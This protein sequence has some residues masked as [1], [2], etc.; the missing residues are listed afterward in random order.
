[1]KYKLLL[2]GTNQ[3]LISD[4]FIHMEANFECMYSS[5]RNADIMCHLKYYHPDAVVFCLHRD[6]KDDISRFGGVLPKLSSER[7]S[8]IIVGEDENCE[9]FERT[10]PMAVDLAIRKPITTRGLEEELLSFL[11]RIVAEKEEQEKNAEWKR[12]KEEKKAEETK[13]ATEQSIPQ[14]FRDRPAT[15]Q[16]AV[17][18]ATAVEEEKKHILVVDDD[19]SVLKMVKGYL[20]EQYNVATAI[21]GKVALKF[22]EKRKTDL[23]LLDYEMPGENGAQVLQKIRSDINLKKLPV[24]FLTGMTE[25]EK[26]KQLMEYKP[27]G[28]LLKPI[29]AKKLTDALEAILKK[30]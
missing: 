23:I 4:F 24:V 6:Y 8:L 20:G 11:E 13:T 5:T 16:A 27:Q 18:P 1:M 30:S 10:L 17:S 25:R 12:E 9:L 14:G 19:S 7:I 21:N 15:P 29:D 28:Y 26:I 3:T 2:T 22:L